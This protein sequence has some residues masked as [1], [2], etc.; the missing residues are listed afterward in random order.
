MRKVGVGAPLA[1]PRSTTAVSPAPSPDR[2]IR[3][4]PPPRALQGVNEAT[5]LKG[6]YLLEADSA[7]ALRTG[8]LSPVQAP[9]SAEPPGGDGSRGRGRALLAG[10]W[11]G[12]PQGPCLLT[13]VSQTSTL[14]ASLTRLLRGL[15][16]AAGF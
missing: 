1:H 8:W 12:E 16:R 15:R 11:E 13:P 6:V 9:G 2:Q 5:H 14:S 4:H 10:F 3:Y 7:E